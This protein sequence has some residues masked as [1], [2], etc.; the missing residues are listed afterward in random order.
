MRLPIMEVTETGI[1]V[2]VLLLIAVGFETLL[3]LDLLRKN[4]NEIPTTRGVAG[5]RGR[6]GQ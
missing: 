6:T 2:F 5:R 3:C 4:A 1:L